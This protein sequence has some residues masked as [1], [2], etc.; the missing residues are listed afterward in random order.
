MSTQSS[1]KFVSYNLRPS[2]QCER[3]MILDSLNA[4]MEC[5]LPIPRLSLCRYGVEPV[6]MI[7]L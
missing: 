6:S 7:L 1:A 3:K 2:K 5:G 4:A